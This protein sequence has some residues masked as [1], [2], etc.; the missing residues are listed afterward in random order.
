MIA[1]ATIETF[2]GLASVRGILL[3]L[4]RAGVLQDIV[5]VAALVAVAIVPF[6]QLRARRHHSS[7]QAGDDRPHAGSTALA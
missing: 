1:I 3:G 7:T 6:H 2:V 5:L 4:G